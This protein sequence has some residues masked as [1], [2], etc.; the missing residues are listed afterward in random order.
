MLTSLRLAAHRSRSG[1]SSNFFKPAKQLSAIINKSMPLI[2]SGIP[3]LETIGAQVVRVKG[4]KAT[5]TCPL[6]DHVR[7]YAGNMHGGVIA[8]VAEAAARAALRS[9]F[10]KGRHATVEM[11][12]NYFRPIPDVPDTKEPQAKITAV[13]ELLSGDSKTCVANVNLFDAAKNLAAAAI[14]TMQR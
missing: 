3:F 6:A 1:I 10:P 7:N 8:A 12:L 4:G 9:T 13:A 14:V 11:K 2:P 5:V